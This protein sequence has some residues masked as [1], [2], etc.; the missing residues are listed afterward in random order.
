MKR[1]GIIIIVFCVV[2]SI[3]TI[4]V[5][6]LETFAVRHSLPDS[7]MQPQHSTLRDHNGTCIYLPLVAKHSIPQLP[8]ISVPTPVGEE[9]EPCFYRIPPPEL[10]TAPVTW[11][12]KGAAFPAY[13]HDSYAQPNAKDY[14]DYLIESGVNT[15]QIVPSWF[16][17][18][19]TSH[20]IMSDT[21]K[22]PTDESIET[23]I[24]Y[25]H[26]Q[27]VDGQR[28]KV[29]LKIH[30][31]PSQNRDGSPGGWRGVI[32]P[33]NPEAW[34]NSYEDFALHYAKLAQRLDVEYYVIGT[35]MASMVQSETN[36]DR[37]VEMADNVRDV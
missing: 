30:L 17:S 28:I 31:E 21:L 8:I 9:T 37:W 23:I 34:F 4:L 13:W 10:Y 12:M 6:N 2:F 16:Q 20:D 22:S 1:I 32:E 26:Q 27:E 19:M 25:I 3:I 5:S 24:E 15:I 7:H 11:T 18:N 33:D 14:V 36:Q 29:M 35:E